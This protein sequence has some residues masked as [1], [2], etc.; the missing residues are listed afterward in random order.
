MNHLAGKISYRKH[1]R[2]FCIANAA[3]RLPGTIWYIAS[4]ANLYQ[5]EGI[6]I[7]ITSM[8]SAL[9]YA[10]VTLSG[11]IGT[12]VFSFSILT[13]YQVS[14]WLM[15]ALLIL[16][17]FLIQ[18]KVINRVFRALKVEANTLK[19][20]RNGL[21]DGCI[22]HPVDDRWKPAVSRDQHHL[23]SARIRPEQC[24]GYLVGRNHGFKDDD[25]SAQ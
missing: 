5:Q 10:F 17:L 7:K 6:D 24:A 8:A 21:L 20:K 23:S 13:E 2:Y 15:G 1:F 19:F 16:T 18:P 4:R 9:E 12:L 25:L 3:K 14:P 11:I 22:F